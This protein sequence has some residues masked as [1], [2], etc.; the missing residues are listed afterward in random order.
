L[1]SRKGMSRRARRSHAKTLASR[2]RW[3]TNPS[4]ADAFEATEPIFR[5]LRVFAFDPSRGNRFGNVMT[6]PVPFEPLRPGPL[7][8]RIAV[9]DYDGARDCFY[10]PVDLNDPL[11]VVSE[12]LEPR[13][14]DPRF[15][16]QMVY[17]VVS[18][19][20]RTFDRALGRA[21]RFRRRGSDRGR[22][23]QLRVYPHGVN[24][25]NAYYSRELHALV[26]GYFPAELGDA[27]P[28][29]PGQP[30]FTCLSHDIIV[31][32]ACHA[33]IDGM[34]QYFLEPTNRDSLAF[35]EAFAD[36]VALLQHFTFR[37]P[38]LETIQRTGGHLYRSHLEPELESDLEGVAEGSGA[39]ESNPLVDLALQFGESLGTRKAL[40]SAIG[41]EPRKSDLDRVMEPHARGAI[42]VAAIFEAFFRVYARRT[43]DLFR[44]AGVGPRHRGELHPDLAQ[45]LCS[46]TTALADQFL[47]LCI[48]AIEYCPPV[49][50]EFGDF[51]RALVTVH[52]RLDQ[53]DRDG[54]REALIRAFV[55]R[56]MF[57]PDVRSMSES[58]LVW[59]APPEAIT[60]PQEL[61]DA[62]RALPIERGDIA[63]QLY[64]F[65]ARHRDAFGLSR[66]ARIAIRSFHDMFK[67]PVRLLGAEFED[68]QD[69]VCELT[70]T[71]EVPA[72]A[73][74]N[75]TMKVRGGTTLVMRNDGRV[76]FAIAKK[77]HAR[78]RQAQVDHAFGRPGSA[79]SLYYDSPSGT[80]F[81]ALHRGY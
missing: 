9:V 36:I 79:A 25:A 50:L 22:A 28:S 14:S 60:A 3:K 49:D 43:R 61:M 68:A 6:I 74:S 67:H 18:R 7:G 44:L 58:E 70:Q 27:G 54:F 76:R 34:R 37:E 46:E 77:L 5:P 11:L 16:Q 48:R 51:L 24:E 78:R 63:V 64:K 30:V 65:C 4:Q 73:R 2:S 33:I 12:G 21:V 81:R 8:E 56:G 55:R 62:L 13:D 47:Q 29:I 71:M 19:T 39:V 57:P 20:L 10:P 32:E 75:V 52:A 35:H 72:F 53:D 38:L 31:H 23:G 40:R 42:L 45:R 17:A 26:F 1:P 15:H 41:V 80:D 59:K 69:F 66:D